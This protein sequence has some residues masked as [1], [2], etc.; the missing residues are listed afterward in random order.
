MIKLNNILKLVVKGWGSVGNSLTAERRNKLA[1]IL[2]SEGSVK[3][4]ELADMFSV[5]TETI[6][7]DL[8]YLDKEG[9]A[10]KSH[11]GA[12][13][14]SELL[15]R[16][17]STKTLENV[18]AKTKIAQAALELIPNKGVIILD[19]GSTTYSI[20]KL[21]TIKKGITI[22]T[23]SISITQILLGTDNT[24]YSLG[25]ETRGSSMALV[26]LWTI[27]ALSTV[28]VDIAFLGT[29]GFFSRNGPCSASFSEAEVKKA[30]I[31]SSKKSV[32]VCDSSKFTTDGMFQ[33]SE[34]KN[35]NYL[36]T[37]SDAPEGEVKN[38]GTVTQII[39]AK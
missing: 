16:P 15:E 23:N 7:K 19:A 13:A 18:E 32:I 25:G 35:I 30:M 2:V 29:D 33:F 27:D 39:K 20:A 8:N 3:V 22:I 1:Q 6:R 26:G 14:S 4:G 28:K 10:K 21:L 12:I 34:W 36:I 9:I 11:G 17:F 37:D 31:Q 38:L 24:V 5:S